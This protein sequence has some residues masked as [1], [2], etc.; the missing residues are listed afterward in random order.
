[1]KLLIVETFPL[2]DNALNDKTLSDI[3]LF[4]RPNN[5]AVE[6]AISTFCAQAKPE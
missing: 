4:L 5:F 3:S 1:M 2:P 6:K